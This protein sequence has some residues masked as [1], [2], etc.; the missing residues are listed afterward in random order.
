MPNNSME[1]TKDTIV[2]RTRIWHVQQTSPISYEPEY[3]MNSY[4][5]KQ[6]YEKDSNSYDKSKDSSS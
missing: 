6:S 4:D 3:G 2:I 1:W 5:H